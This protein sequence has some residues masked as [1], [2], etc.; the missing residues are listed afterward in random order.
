[1]PTFGMT[2]QHWFIRKAVHGLVRRAGDVR[3]GGGV[4]GEVDG[5]PRN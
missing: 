5:D 4:A 2:G 3:D 1:M